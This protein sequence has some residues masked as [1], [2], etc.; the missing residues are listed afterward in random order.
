MVVSMTV[1]ILSGHGM[2]PG[3]GGAGW[4]LKGKTLPLIFSI[5]GTNQFWARLV[6]Y[7]MY[8]PQILDYFKKSF[9]HLH[10]FP[11]GQI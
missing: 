5:K 7:P 3:G 4:G 10:Q 11:Y 8:Y 6:Y 1:N 2:S 9:H